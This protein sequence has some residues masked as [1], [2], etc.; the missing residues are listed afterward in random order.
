MRNH[1]TLLTVLV[2]LAALFCPTP[3]FGQ[4]V[5]DDGANGIPDS[6]GFTADCP[7]W[8]AGP[9]AMIG[10]WLQNDNVDDANPRPI[11]VIKGEFYPFSV[12][13]IEW[14]DA[15]ACITVDDSGDD[16]LASSHYVD[17]DQTSWSPSYLLIANGQFMVTPA[18]GPVNLNFRTDDQEGEYDQNG[19]RVY[20]QLLAG[21][22]YEGDVARWQYHGQGGAVNLLLFFDDGP[23]KP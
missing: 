17:E 13:T 9:T 20:E 2:V 14:I 11:P 18:T 12:E 21:V 23:I 5:Y 22:V 8:S 16:G 15:G 19:W 4:I 1:R 3:T 10:V 7:G 6:N